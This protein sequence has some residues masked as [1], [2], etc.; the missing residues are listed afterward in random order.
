MWLEFL[1]SAGS[2]AL[3]IAGI[4]VF[5]WIGLTFTIRRVNKGKQRTTM[6]HRAEDL[7]KEI[8][9]EIAERRKKSGLAK[10]PPIT[11]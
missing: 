6:E 9:A 3:I 8:D 10:H 4:A 2:I 5:F 11:A 7:E 1:E